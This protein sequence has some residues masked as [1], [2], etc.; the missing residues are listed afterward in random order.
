M[1]ISNAPRA[2]RPPQTSAASHGKRAQW[3]VA[4]L[5]A[6]ALFVAACSGSNGHK[7]GAAG[8]T[9]TVAGLEQPSVRCGAPHTKATL[10]RFKAAD[11]ISLDGVMVGDGKA[12]VVLVHEYPADLCGFWPF[13]N[14]LARHGLRAFAIDLRCF[15]QSECPDGAAKHRVIEDIAAAAATL[16]AARGRCGFT[17]RRGRPNQARRRNPPQRGSGC[18]AT[19]GPDY[20]RCRHQRHL[21][22]GPETRLMYQAVKTGNKRL[23]VLSGPF[24]ARHGWDLLT[25]PADA[26]FSPVAAKVTAFVSANT[27]D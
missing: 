11:G 23:S 1:M 3:M 9:T 16:A 17:V 4:G 13:A 15:G 2:I 18:E 7:R 14:Y 19:H 10:V 8:A 21:R 12:G 27:R 24:D 5:A 26:T 25:N 22:P 20:V 6:V